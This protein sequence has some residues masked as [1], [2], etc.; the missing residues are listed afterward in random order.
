MLQVVGPAPDEGWVFAILKGRKG[1][2][3]VTHL[4]MPKAAAAE[5]HSMPGARAASS[6]I[7][8][9]ADAGAG[10]GAGRYRPRESTSPADKTLDEMTSVVDRLFAPS[11][12][13]ALL[14]SLSL[15]CTQGSHSLISVH[16]LFARAS[17]FPRFLSTFSAAFCRCS[18]PL[19]VDVL[20]RFL[21]Q[22]W[23]V[24]CL[25]WLFTI[26]LLHSIHGLFATRP[27]MLTASRDVWTLRRMLQEAGHGGKFEAEDEA[28]KRAERAMAEQAM[29]PQPSPGGE[30][31]FFFTREQVEAYFPLDVPVA[32]EY[33]AMESDELSLRPGQVVRVIY[34]FEDEWWVVAELGNARGIVPTPYLTKMVFPDEGD[35]KSSKPDWLDDRPLPVKN[36]PA[37]AGAVSDMRRSGP[38]AE[39][40]PPLQDPIPEGEGRSRHNSL[41]F[42]PQVETL[43]IYLRFICDSS[44]TSRSVSF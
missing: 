21:R 20:C 7:G 16:G 32:W 40:L 23:W 29:R 43:S 24:C 31:G 9:D 14:V 11:A 36:L 39:K 17:R 34:P 28:L 37:S 10:A 8:Y 33:E 30:A 22:G 27:V 4:T 25:H 13:L 5:P 26:S 41:E 35:V 42:L 38:V 44:P 6:T 18:L 19:F 15:C 12:L 2:A 3:P 1:L